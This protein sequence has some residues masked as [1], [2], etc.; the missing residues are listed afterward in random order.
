MGSPLLRLECTSTVEKSIALIGR[1][2]SRIKV[3]HSDV[4]AATRIHKEI[5]AI[6]RRI[7]SK[8]FTPVAA[9]TPVQ[10][11]SICDPTTVTIH[12]L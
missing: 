3:R 11:D 7:F 8:F 1:Y 12:P 6:A 9:A 10:N 4:T 5:A 2:R